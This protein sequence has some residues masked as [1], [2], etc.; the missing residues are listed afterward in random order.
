MIHCMDHGMDHGIGRIM[1][2]LKE[3]DEDKN[4]IVLFLSDNGAEGVEKLGWD[5]PDIVPGG[6]DTY[7]TCGAAWGF[8]QNTPIRGYKGSLYE[9][10]IAS[11][12]IVR[13]PKTRR[14]RGTI[15]N[16]LA[17]AMD[18]MPTLCELA[19]IEYPKEY[20]GQVL[21]P[22]E[23][24]SLVPVFRG[25]Q[26]DGHQVLVWKQKQ[27]RAVRQD[28]WKLIRRGSR[29]DS[30]HW[31]RYDLEADRSELHDLGQEQPERL[32]QMVSASHE[33]AEQMREG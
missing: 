17:H 15:S 20:E 24:K 13:W 26:R 11:P 30:N 9:G 32:K 18:I 25:N 7:C 8:L 23:G 14:N 1:R 10:G 29:G 27:R 4:S 19:G 2:A 12:V 16:Q 21:S 33:W 5:R 6:I 22:C 3:I 28:N 31:K